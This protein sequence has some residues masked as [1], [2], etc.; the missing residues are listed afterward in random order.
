MVA[1]NVTYNGKYRTKAY[2]LYWGEI[3]RFRDGMYVWVEGATL[4][5]N[6][7]HGRVVKG[8]GHLGHDEAMEAGGRE[9]NPRPGHYSRMSF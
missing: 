8:V 5:G 1:N 6:R 7:L 2:M 3:S 9:F 4:I